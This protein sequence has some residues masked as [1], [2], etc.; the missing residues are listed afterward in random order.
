[1]P[2]DIPTN[3]KS[4]RSDLM[5][6]LKRPIAEMLRDFKGALR[7]EPHVIGTGT[8]MVHINAAIVRGKAM[9]DSHWE[10]M[11]TT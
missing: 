3:L 10:L 8:P 1:M 6:F 2:E 5:G 4:R 11:A 9:R 7:T